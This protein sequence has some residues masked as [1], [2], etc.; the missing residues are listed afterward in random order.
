MVTTSDLNHFQYQQS[1]GLELES[2]LTLFVL[3]YRKLRFVSIYVAFSSVIS[4]TIGKF[5]FYFVL[6]T[7]QAS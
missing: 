1:Q 6:I 3:A 7:L 2:F 4:L 5:G